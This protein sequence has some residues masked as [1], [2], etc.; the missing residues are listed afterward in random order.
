[1]LISDYNVRDEGNQTGSVTDC[2]GRGWQITV[3]RVAREGLSQGHGGVRDMRPQNIE[4]RTCYPN[5]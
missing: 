1:M 3:N 2:H 4:F 5:P